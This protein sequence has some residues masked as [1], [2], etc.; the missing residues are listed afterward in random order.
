MCFEFTEWSHNIRLKLNQQVKESWF[1]ANSTHV[2]DLVFHL[3]GLPVLEASHFLHSV[4]L[5]GIQ[6]LL[7][8]TDAVLLPKISLLH[9]IL[10][11]RHL[12]VGRSS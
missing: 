12:V 8:F 7:V 9:I 6:H 10:T 4:R 11:G 5:I 3:I 2:V 1:L